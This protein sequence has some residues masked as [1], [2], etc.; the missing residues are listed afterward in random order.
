MGTG[1]VL[2]QHPLLRGVSPP[3]GVQGRSRAATG[4]LGMCRQ[5]R[6]G[7][8]EVLGGF[9]TDPCTLVTIAVAAVDTGR[10]CEAGC[11]TCMDVLVM[12]YHS[13]ME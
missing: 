3:V 12:E 8:Q 11:C 13:R 4:N 1:M 6:R 5:M 7:G 9:P 10:T 2:L